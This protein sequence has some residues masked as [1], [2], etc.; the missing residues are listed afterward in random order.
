M[1]RLEAKALGMIGE[2]DLQIKE[3]QEKEAILQYSLPSLSLVSMD[4]SFVIGR[5]ITTWTLA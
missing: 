2:W 4:G 1:G 5:L 3:L